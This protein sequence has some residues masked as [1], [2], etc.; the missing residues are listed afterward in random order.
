MLG[1]ACTTDKIMGARLSWYG[2]VIEE[3]MKTTSHM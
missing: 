3:R 2:Q 1:V